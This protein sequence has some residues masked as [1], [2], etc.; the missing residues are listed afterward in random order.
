MSAP[1]DA[2]ERARAWQH[3]IQAAV[4]DVFDPWEFGTVVRAPR[5]PGYFD[6]NLVRVE[7]EPSMSVEALVAFTDEALA[8]HTHRRLDFEPADVGDP[9]RP[10]FKPYGYASERLV[11]MRHA[12]ARPDLPS[13]VLVEEVPYETARPLRM[14]WFAEDFPDAQLG[15][16]LSEAREVALLLG[17]RVF[18]VIEG[19][20][21]VAYAQLE[22]VGQSAEIRQ[23]YVR[24]DH[25]GRGIGTALTCAAIDAAG[26]P[27]ELWIVAD[28]EGRPKELYAR[29]GFDPVW[30]AVQLLRPPKRA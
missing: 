23:L 20:E 7:R 28:D 22:R 24:P 27:E 16:H 8:D 2:A 11:W 15:D 26:D 6:F 25:R 19:R 1:G 21:S 4:C 17:A 5:Y 18:A 9:L 30:R 14:Q 10:A 13:E 3:G 29:L 12:R